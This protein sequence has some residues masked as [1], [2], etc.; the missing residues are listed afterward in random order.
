MRQ[1]LGA[2]AAAPFYRSRVF[3]VPGR[4]Q[5]IQKTGCKVCIK[6]TKLGRGAGGERKRGGGGEGGKSCFTPNL[7]ADRGEKSFASST[8]N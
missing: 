2:A 5:S 8:I 6:T 1:K 7:R 4:D 3:S